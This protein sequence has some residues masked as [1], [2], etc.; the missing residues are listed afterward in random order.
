MK[1]LNVFGIVSPLDR[2]KQLFH[3]TWHV[4]TRAV[5]RTGPRSVSWVIYADP[6]GHGRIPDVIVAGGVADTR[7]Q[8]DEA[9]TRSF[10]LWTIA[11]PAGM[12]G[13]AEW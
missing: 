13:R 9:M 4:A 12:V 3:A 7:A 10:E 5:I 8:A 1:M 11:G 6:H 2:A